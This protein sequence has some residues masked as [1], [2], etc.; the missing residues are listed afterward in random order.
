[1]AGALTETL[2]RML[3]VERIVTSVRQ[4]FRVR[5]STLR[6]APRRRIVSTAG[7]VRRDLFPNFRGDAV[8][9][10]PGLRAV[11]IAEANQSGPGTYDD[12]EIVLTPENA[13]IPNQLWKPVE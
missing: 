7:V 11:A 10:V 8:L 9:S 1:V 3:S 5:G 2:D 13:G 4:L 12:P 6:A